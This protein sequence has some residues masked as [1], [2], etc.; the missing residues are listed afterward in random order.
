M[1]TEATD[2]E[3]YVEQLLRLP[4]VRG[5]RIAELGPIRFD[6]RLDAILAI[7]TPTGEEQLLVEH[8]RSLLGRGMAEHL[9]SLASSVP[10][11]MV[12]TPVVGRAV[13]DL[14]AQS[15]VNFIDLAGNCNLHI[16]DHYHAR[17]QGNRR[18]RLHPSERAMRAPA[19]RVLFALL[20]RPELVDAPTRDMA[21][22][23]GTVSPQTA[24]DLRSRLVVAGWVLSSCSSH[25]WAPE[26][27]RRAAELWLAGFTTTLF[28][29][30]SIGRFRASGHDVDKIEATLESQ[31]GAGRSWRW[32]GGAAAQRLTGYYRG[33]RTLL[34]LA[35]PPS[36]P[37]QQLHL[38]PDADGDIWL[39]RS[40]GPLAY[41]GPNQ[42]TV[43]PLL[44]YADLIGEGHERARDAAAEVRRRFLPD[45]ERDAEGT[46]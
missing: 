3:A 32:G 5:A 23:A 15:N 7:Q 41:S 37:A 38:V 14:F 33:D 43:H 22:A 4:F 35:D 42:A 36:N 27:K 34:Y 39:A 46:R 17:V 18:L 28:P 30:L 19:H 1:K 24:N 2:L 29:N 6:R 40:P 44:V 11:L 31:L 26:G 13:G 12:M 16:G 45:L 20:V 8:K 21:E 9:A 10:G 25:R